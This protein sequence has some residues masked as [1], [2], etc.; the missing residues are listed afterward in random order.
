MLKYIAAAAVA[1]TFATSPALAD[2]HR[3]RDRDH[4]PHHSYRDRDHHDRRHYRPG[5]RYDRAPH[6]WHRYRHRPHDWRTRGCIVV[7]PL[8]FCP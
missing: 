7:G 6:G 2:P 3:D 8:W 1:I 5:S 4:R